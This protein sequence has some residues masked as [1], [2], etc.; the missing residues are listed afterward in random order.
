MSR[1]WYGW[2]RR[3]SNL[4]S[5]IELPSMCRIIIKRVRPTRMRHRNMPETMYDYSQ[6]IT[7]LPLRAVNYFLDSGL[8][9]VGS[10]AK[11]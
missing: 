5:N 2:S 8:G 1:G 4:V 10:S 11:T 3:R 6:I 7:R 9:T